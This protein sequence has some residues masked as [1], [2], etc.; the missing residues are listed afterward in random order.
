MK[1]LVAVGNIDL[2]FR[3]KLEQ[4][5]KS[6]GAKSFFIS[7]S[8]DPSRLSNLVSSDSLVVVDIEQTSSNIDTIASYC[9]AGKLIGFYPHVRKDLLLKA[10]DAGLSMIIP[11]SALEQV[12]K[13]ALEKMQH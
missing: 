12:V 9:N 8:D 4:M 1:T 10:K 2:F 13:N 7:S 11:R 5:A 6:A 3:A